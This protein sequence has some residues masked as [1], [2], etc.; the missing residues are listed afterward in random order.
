[1]GYN[2]EIT[3]YYTISGALVRF[4]EVFDGVVYG[5]TISGSLFDAQWPTYSY[6]ITYNAWDETTYSG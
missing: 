1:M 6:S 3:E 5:R 2:P 4:E